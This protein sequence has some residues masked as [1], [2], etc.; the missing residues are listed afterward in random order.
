VSCSL[1][2]TDGG[3]RLVLILIINKEIIETE[4]NS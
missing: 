4:S 1:L 3:A 2:L